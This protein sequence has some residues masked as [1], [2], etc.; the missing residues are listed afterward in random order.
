MIKF[1]HNTM[2]NINLYLVG[3]LHTDLDGKK[4]LDILLNRLS[5][6]IVALEFHKEREDFTPLRKS[7]KEEQKE[8]NAMIGESDLTLS[9]RQKATLIESTKRICNALD[10]EFKSSRD[11]VARN[12][13]SRLE[14]IDISFF[15]NGREEFAKG[16]N[17]TVKYMLKSVAEEPELAKTFLKRFDGGIGAVLRNFRRHVNEIYKN[18]EEMAE[19]MEIIRKPESFEMMSKKMSPKAIQSL[20]QIYDPKR[21]ENMGKR[22]RELYDGKSRLV[23]VV[24]LAHLHALK[25]KVSDLE[26]TAITLAEYKS[27]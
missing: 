14:Y 26:P 4:R 19:L 2:D 3:T 16:A 9:P 1:N 24:G 13:N 25:T 11:Y 10:Y 12:K 17:E 23:A 8:I 22:V 20:K 18:A 27:V 21:D 15:T 5:P 7:Q 6:S